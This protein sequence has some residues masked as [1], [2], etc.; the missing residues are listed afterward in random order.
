MSA[1][2]VVADG[3]AEVLVP[4]LGAVDIVD[5]A[6]LSAG[7]NRETWSFDAVTGDGTRHEL[8]LQ[9]ERAGFT[10]VF[11]TGML[12]RWMSVSAKPIA[13]GAN[14]GDARFAVAPRMT[15]RNPKVITI[16]VHSAEDIE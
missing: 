14:P 16:S 12:M 1:A 10:D 15:I 9:R 2:D 4:E 13:I 6:R 11:V 3:L 5:L 8:I 7:A